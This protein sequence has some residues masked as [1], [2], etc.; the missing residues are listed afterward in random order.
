YEYCVDRLLSSPRY[1]EHRARYWLDA[2]RYGD[3]HGL[4][5]DNERSIWPYRTWVVDAFN[6]DQPFDQFTIE[7]LA[8]DLLPHPSVEQ[9]VATGFLRCNVTT[10][11]GGSIDE[12]YVVRYAMDRT[13]T[14]STVWLGL[15]MGCAACHDHK[16]DP[17]SQREYYSLYSYFFS[18]AEN[19]MDGNALLPP[20]AMRVA[21]VAQQAQREQF[22]HQRTRLTDTLAQLKRQH[23]LQLPQFRDDYLSHSTASVAPRDWQLYCAFNEFDE[24]TTPAGR[25]TTAQ[26]IGKTAVDAGRVASAIRLQE[27]GHLN[28]GSTGD[29]EQHDAFTLATW[30]YL[31]DDG[32]TGD[33]VMSLAARWNQEQQR[34]YEVS[35]DARQLVVQISHHGAENALIVRTQ[36][37][38]TKQKWQHLAVSYD[39]SNRATGIT[40]CVNGEPQQLTI[41]RDQLNGTIRTAGPLLIG[42][43]NHAPF[44]GMLD[45]FYLFAR[46]LDANEITALGNPDPLLQLLTTDAQH[47]T[48]ETQA[49]IAHELLLRNVSEY[50][51]AHQ[52]K[53]D[54]EEALRKLEGRYASTLIAEELSH[55]RVAHML[56]RGQYDQKTQEVSRD[57]PACL[58]P[59][60]A[61]DGGNRHDLARWL[62]RADHPL[63]ARVAVNRLWAQFFGI[64]LVATP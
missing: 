31:E 51:T 38:L 18:L 64:G 7:Q 30:L 17:I 36:L 34:G 55:P 63:T 60:S 53:H 61:S 32:M 13:E 15:T 57:V 27:G 24:H 42:N 12:E 54:I 5:L 48:T 28:L 41:E 21:N 10:S 35:L 56:V 39:G 29:L 4:H 6:R 50:R 9:K 22:E 44:F 43:G 26:R 62:V 25:G 11:E 46:Q 37:P 59:L 8:G 14:M 20:P 3:T 58:P 49:T 16:F 45:E 33:S 19:A 23:L 47:A 1:G 52:A 2:A 40:V